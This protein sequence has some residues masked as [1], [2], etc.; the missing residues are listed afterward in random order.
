MNTVSGRTVSYQFMVTND[1]VLN[2]KGAGM[3]LN[4]QGAERGF[5]SR[6]TASRITPRPRVEPN[7]IDFSQS[8]TQILSSL[9]NNL[10]E[11]PREG[12]AIVSACT[13]A[14]KD[15]MISRHNNQEKRILSL[16]HS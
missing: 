12:F 2:S 5:S 10:N 4:N 7:S 16:E 6:P 11:D 14:W 3:D 8:L 15:T 1:Q 9:G 13:D